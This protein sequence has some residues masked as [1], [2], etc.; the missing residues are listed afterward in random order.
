[1]LFLC[2]ISYGLQ[3]LLLKVLFLQFLQDNILFFELTESQ[4]ENLHVLFNLLGSLG[5]NLTSNTI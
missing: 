2:K 5:L 3:V 1:M 4:Q